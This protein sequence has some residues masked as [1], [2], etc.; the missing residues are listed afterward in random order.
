MGRDRPNGSISAFLK[1][2]AALCYFGGGSYHDIFIFHGISKSEFYECVL[3]V[4]LDAVNQ[5]FR[6]SPQYL[7]SHQMQKKI[8]KGFSSKS[9]AGFTN[10]AG[11]IDGILLWIEKPSEAECL[12]IEY[13]CGR[14]GKYGLN[15]QAVC[16]NIY[17]YIY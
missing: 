16:D 15:L 7:S 4:V 9:A 13:Y 11:C 3:D 6:G 17:I 1:L 14:K 8:V 10:C 2:S 5:H 12:R